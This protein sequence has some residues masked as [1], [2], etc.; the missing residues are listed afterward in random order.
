M[1]VTYQTKFGQSIGI[2]GSIPQFGSWNKDHIFRMTWTEGHEWVA[3]N[4]KISVEY[5]DKPHFM[6]KYVVIDNGNLT[7]YEE[8]I[9]R[10]AD[11][12]L[13]AKQ[14][15]EMNLSYIENKPVQYQMVN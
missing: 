7:R 13:L 12:K 8:G 2:L 14:Q 4:V 9:D 3:E 6:Y 11:L 1:K 15:P 10:I 5:G